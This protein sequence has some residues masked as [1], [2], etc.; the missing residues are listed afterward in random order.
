MSK[1]PQKR[2]SAAR[3]HTPEDKRQ[4]QGG[5]PYIMFLY[6]QKR[7]L[8]V[9]SEA[10]K[11]SY[12]LTDTPQ[13]TETHPETR[14]GKSNK[15]SAPERIKGKQGA[16]RGEFGHKWA[17]IGIK[18]QEKTKHP[19]EIIKTT[20]KHPKTPPK[21]YG[22]TFILTNSQTPKTATPCKQCIFIFS[23]PF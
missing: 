6:I 10:K 14:G 8:F 18:T 9:C 20:Q 21:I 2:Q 11:Y 7:C 22:I 4:G 12:S 16:K 19:P 17:H 13:R 5:N 3:I 1:P 23:C 15:T